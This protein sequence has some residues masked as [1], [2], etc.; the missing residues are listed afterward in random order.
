MILVASPSKPLQ[1]NA[2]G[3]PRR[4]VSLAAYKAEIDALYS[5]VERSAQSDV[6][7]PPAWDDSTTRAFLRTV[8]ARVLQRPAQDPLPDDADLFRSGCDRCVLAFPTQALSAEPA[9][10]C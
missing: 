4:A 5:E 9:H 7:A 2:K 1:L 10:P 3:Y 6:R 8:V